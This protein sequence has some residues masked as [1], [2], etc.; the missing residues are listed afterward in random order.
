MS[1]HLITSVVWVIMA[2]IGVSIVAVLVSKKSNTAGVIS[3]SGSEFS[4]ILGTAVSPLLGGAGCHPSVS[5]SISF[6]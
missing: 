6:G 1:E 2:I 3:A 4:C 5:S